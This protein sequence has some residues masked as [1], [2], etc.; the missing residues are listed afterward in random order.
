MTT[1]SRE[2]NSALADLVSTHRKAQG[3]SA[4]SVAQ[5]AG[6][7]IH[8]MVGLEKGTYASP[9]PLTLKGVSK[10]LGIP[11]L[12]LFHAAGYVTP[13]DLVDLVTAPSVES[14]LA[15]Q[16]AIEARS[17]YIAELIE[18]HGLDYTGPD[19]IEAPDTAN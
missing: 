2:I 15:E 7:D 13:Y 11:L 19:L 8:T 17:R 9:S 10:A 1:N 14:L 4:R 5:E 3:R 6:I 18:K 12:E 16:D